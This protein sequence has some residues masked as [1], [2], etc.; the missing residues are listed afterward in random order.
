MSG[1]ACRARTRYSAIFDRS[2][3]IRISYS[4]ALAKQ[5]T[6]ESLSFFP[7]TGANSVTPSEISRSSRTYSTRQP[8][9][10]AAASSRARH[11]SPSSTSGS[12]SVP[13]CSRRS[14]CN[15]PFTWSLSKCVSTRSSTRNTHR[16]CKYRA[17]VSPASSGTP[18]QSTTIVLPPEWY[19]RHCPCP[20]SSIVNVNS[21]AR[22]STAAHP[23]HTPKQTA[24]AASASHLRTASGLTA[25]KITKP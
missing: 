16:L 18:P 6:P 24:A 25:I 17:A 5:Q 15:A 4:P 21:A 9:S 1:S 3:V 13:T 19:T 12:H 11:P 7:E 2:P 22:Y 8:A 20:T 14:S 10:S 23:R